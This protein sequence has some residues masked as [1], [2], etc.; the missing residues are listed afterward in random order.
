MKKTVVF[1]VLMLVTG[2]HCSVREDKCVS[3]LRNIYLFGAWFGPVTFQEIFLAF[4]E[5][6]I[7]GTVL[8]YIG[9]FA[10]FVLL[11]AAFTISAGITNS[12]EPPM[13]N[14]TLGIVL[15]LFFT[16]MY[17]R[18]MELS[19]NEQH[20]FGND[21]SLIKELISTLKD[22]K[23]VIQEFLMLAALIGGMSTVQILYTGKK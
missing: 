22:L 23:K 14:A 7:I 15:I 4:Q 17:R 13:P 1:V 6:A 20:S 21:R 9:S 2:D 19:E 10:C 5:E 11:V 3:L 12:E 16:S 8:F 18:Y